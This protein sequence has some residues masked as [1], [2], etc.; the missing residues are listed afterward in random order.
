MAERD[1]PI[2]CAIAGASGRM[3][4]RLL[5]LA[6]AD[7]AFEVVSAWVGPD[8]ARLGQPVPG[9]A[10]LTYSTAGSGPVQP[11]V[12]VDFSVA[13]G[14][15]RIVAACRQ[16]GAALVCGTTGLDQAQ[17]DAL[18]AAASAIPVLWSANF[19][20]GV[21]VLTRAVAQAAR[22]L[23]HWQVEI[24]EAHHAGKRDAPS[25]TALALGEAVAGARGQSLAARAVFDRHGQASVREPEAIGFA[26]LRAGDIVGEHTVV[27]AGTGERLELVHR[28]G[29]RG[30]FAGG[31]LHAARWLAGRPAGQ[32]RFEDTL[33]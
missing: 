11:D 20:L 33:G 19:A 26:V 21:A 22:M 4:E 7:P 13:L 8:S 23:P 10:T 15:D 6:V 32:Y 29:D 2:R 31:A 5:A 17:R 12:V 14:L 24:V 28:A 25:G 30:I 16:H 9:I 3:G 1:R 18:A 27:L